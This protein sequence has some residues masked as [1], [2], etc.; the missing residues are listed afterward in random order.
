LK[1]NVMLVKE[2]SPAECAD[3]MAINQLAHAYAQAI[4]RGLV[5]EAVQT[6]APDG[7]L[8]T[9]VLEPVS[10]RDAI[11]AAIHAGTKDLD[12]VFH[13]VQNAL[14][15][16]HGDRADA[17]FQLSEWSRR[18]SDGATFLWLGFYDDELV[19]LPEGWRFAKR[20]LVSRIMAHADVAITKIYPVSALRPS[21]AASE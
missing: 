1:E 3:V 6:Y 7:T 17:R 8:T 18:K 10:G 21:F 9:P 12:M 16:V 5:H 14:V 13:C 15:Q 11:E 19:R 2:P 20:T 4:S